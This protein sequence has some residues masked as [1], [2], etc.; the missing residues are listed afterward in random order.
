MKQNWLGP[1]QGFSKHPPRI[2]P[3]LNLN[4]LFSARFIKFLSLARR[5]PATISLEIQR[6]PNRPLYSPASRELP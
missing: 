1:A 3:S 5:L 4:N 6:W 2:P